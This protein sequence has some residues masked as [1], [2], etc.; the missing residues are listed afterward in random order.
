[1]VRLCGVT[2]PRL[3]NIATSRRHECATS[4]HFAVA[5]LQ[6][7]DTAIV[8]RLDVSM[9]NRFGTTMP[10]CYAF[11]PLCCCAIV[12][13]RCHTAPPSQHHDALISCR[14]SVSHAQYR[15][16]VA[17]CGFSTAM[18]CRSG[19]APSSWRHSVVS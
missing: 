4:Q 3:Q 12:L 17:L 11:A 19:V 15:A 14:H 10:W 8:Q 13:L 18:S 16:I 6:Y 9:L 7:Y 5:A 1:M 2:I